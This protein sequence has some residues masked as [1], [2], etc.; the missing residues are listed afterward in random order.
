[1]IRLAAFTVAFAS[2]I[3]CAATPVAETAPAVQA[4]PTP[5][6]ESAPAAAPTET[7]LAPLNELPQLPNDKQ[8]TLK[9]SAGTEV[10]LPAKE[11]GEMIE[12]RRTALQN[13]MDCLGA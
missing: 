13:L 3:S 4:T 12:Q 7:K 11:A 2:L 10:E 1:M 8:V 5:A 6:A 9:D